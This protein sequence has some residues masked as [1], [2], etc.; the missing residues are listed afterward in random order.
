M[1]F[2]RRPREWEA[3]VEAALQEGQVEGDPVQELWKAVADLQAALELAGI[4]K[5]SAC[6]WEQRA[7]QLE[8]E[9][10]KRQAEHSSEVSKLRERLEQRDRAIDMVCGRLEPM[11]A[12]LSSEVR[13]QLLETDPETI[14][15]VAKSTYRSFRR[16]YG[17]KYEW[18]KE[19]LQRRQDL[20]RTIE[21]ILKALAE[22]PSS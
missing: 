9:L 14:H 10:R 12:E 15:A 11:R 18:E 4:W 20:E 21:V 13:A 2:H 1:A 5:N 7:R 8:E 16:Q 19:P 17:L 3:R 6:N 22:H